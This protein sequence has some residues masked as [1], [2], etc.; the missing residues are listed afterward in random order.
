[1]NVIHSESYYNYVCFT[2]PELPHTLCPV[3]PASEDRWKRYTK[4]AVSFQ[5]KDDKR[6]TVEE[7]ALMSLRSALWKTR[8]NLSFL[9]ISLCTLLLLEIMACLQVYEFYCNIFFKVLVSNI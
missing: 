4:S 2:V 1:M 8:E 6:K 5:G 9:N 3:I 7:I